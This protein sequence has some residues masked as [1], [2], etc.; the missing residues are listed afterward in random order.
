MQDKHIHLDIVGGIA[1]DMFISAMIDSQ[2]WL[3]PIVLDSISK[4]VPADVG[5]ARIAK[6]INKGISGLTFKLELVS[7]SAHHDHPHP[8][9]HSHSHRHDPRTTYSGICQML[10]DSDL[11]SEVIKIAKAILTIIGKAEAKIHNKTLDE[12]HFHELADWDSV[13]DV[14]AIASIFE[15]LQGCVWSIS[16]LPIG[17]GLVKT[18]HGLLPVPAPATAEILNGF[19][20]VDD[21]VGGER[22]TPTGAAILAYLQ[23]EKRLVA[24]Q[25]AQLT[26]IGYGLGTKQLPNMPNILRAMVFQHGSSAAYQDSIQVIEFD[27]DDMTGE[28]IAV[29]AEKIRQQTG[30]IDLISYSARGKKNR[31]L[32][33]FRILARCEQL[34][35]IIKEC[36]QQTSTIGLRYFK[37][38]RNCLHREH[39]EIEGIKAKCVTREGYQSIKVENDELIEMNTLQARRSAKFN[40]EF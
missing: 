18:A 13:M 35:T 25:A 4:L 3:E 40:R 29:A 10:E 14:V 32:E 17:G 23:Q 37:A 36:F 6:G 38:N 12:V 28:E 26:A 21:G 16:N 22:I 27:I 31:P 34:H 11:Q 39:I 24:K 19:T 5:V 30:V 1:G 9:S 7:N 33:C 20:F 15:Q 2:S 8:H